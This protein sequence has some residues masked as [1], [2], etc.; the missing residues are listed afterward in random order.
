[1]HWCGPLTRHD[2]HD[3]HCFL[4]YNCEKSFDPHSMK[5]TGTDQ[6]GTVLCTSTVKKLC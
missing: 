6:Y 4:F 1:M 3:Y 5:D 2:Y